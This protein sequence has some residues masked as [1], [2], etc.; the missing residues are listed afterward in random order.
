MF[1]KRLIILLVA[2]VFLFPATVEGQYTDLSIPGDHTVLN[3]IWQSCKES[4][5]Q[6]SE[7]VYDHVVNGIGWF[8]VHQGPKNEFAV[9]YNVIDPHRDHDSPE[10]QLGKKYKVEVDAGRAHKE[11]DFWVQTPEGERIIYDFKVT[12]A[13]GSS[14]DCES[15]SIVLSRRR[16]PS[17]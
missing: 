14:S 9:F 2:A 11:W 8:E 5:G 12:L 13:G 3:G 1:S 4:D 7:R 6:Y 17:H 16:K 15:W 10:N